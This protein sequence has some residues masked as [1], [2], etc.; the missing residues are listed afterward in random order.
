MNDNIGTKVDPFEILES[1]PALV[2]RL[3]HKDNDWSTLF[4]TKNISIY[5]YTPE[6]FMEGETK[7]LDIV[8]PDDRALLM[9]QINDYEERKINNFRLFYRLIT[10]DGDSIPVSEHNTIHR[11]SN[12]SIDCY[13]TIIISSAHS[14][15]GQKLLADYARQQ[16]TLNDILIS[17]HDSDLDHALQIILDRTGTYLDT[18]R[19]LLFK[20]SPDH[21]TCSV[22][23]EWCNSGITSIKDRHYAIA[24]AAQIPEI[25]QALQDTGVLLINAGGIPENC[26]RKFKN[27]GLV[28]SAI[29]AVYLN[30][31]HYGFVCFDDCV[32][33]RVWDDDTA[34]FLKNISNLISTVLARQDAAQKLE[35]SMKITETVLDNV[36]SYIFAVHPED[37]TI[38]FANKAFKNAF[39]EN[40]E[41]LN[42]NLYINLASLTNKRKFTLLRAVQELEENSQEYELEEVYSAKIKKWLNIAVAQVAWVDGQIAKLVTCHDI[43][44]KKHYADAME[45]AAFLDH[46]TSMSNRYRCDI[47]LPEAVR[48]AREAKSAGYLLFIDMDDFKIVNDCYGHDYGDGVLIS[49]ANYLKKEFKAP[50]KVFRFG[51]DEFVILISHEHSEKIDEYIAKLLAR[52]AKP[53]KALDKKFYCTLSIGAVRF[54]CKNTSPKDIIKHADLALYEAKKRGKNNFQF[55][56]EGLDS[57]TLLRSQMETLLRRAMAN[58]FQGFEVY[59]QPIVSSGDNR[60]LGAEALVR[61]Y[62]EEGNIVLP[63]EFI[64]LAEYLGFMVP[65]GEYVFRI[66]CLE[67]AKINRA[68]DPDFSITINISEKQLNQRDILKRIES[69]LNKTKIQYSNVYISIDES[70]AI[71]DT[72]RMLFIAAQLKELGI[73]TVMSDFGGGNASFMRIR[74]LPIEIV[75][76]S[77]ALMDSIADPYSRNFIELMINW[78]HS[79]NKK[80]CINGVQEKTHYN[81]SKDL[82]ADLLQGFYFHVP[83]RSNELK[84][85]LD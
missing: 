39:E 72:K 33:E 37:D 83:Y 54:P 55:Y 71:S 79:M 30:G 20:N 25:Y 45:Q 10:K 9:K 26:R 77:V 11:G 29:F 52:A 73:R 43:T 75:K 1:V 69:T 32:V 63:V 84:S 24:Y 47:D 68:I 44:A 85:S 31:E 65:I 36:D 40:C 66:A 3:S 58:D 15:M 27:E 70:S 38:I 23:Y 60:I 78:C 7:W 13:D 2:M 22:V 6:E 49:F 51:G 57:D 14:E 64:P 4:I 16:F 34:S 8:H 48:K 19:V 67:C 5:G 61:M 18:S 12:G 56:R 82:A 62:D 74:D 46:L 81:F 50:D 53:W 41:G 42:C 80:V 35:S 76:T 59:Y 21:K 28:A 17:L